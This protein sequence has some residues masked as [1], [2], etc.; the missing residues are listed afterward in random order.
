MS[1]WEGFDKYC[2]DNDIVP[3]EEPAA[4]AAYLHSLTGWDGHVEKIGEEP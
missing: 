4:F 3:G 2:G 1:V